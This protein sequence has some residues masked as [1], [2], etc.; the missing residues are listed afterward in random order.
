MSESSTGGENVNP[1]EVEDPS[2]GMSSIKY[3]DDLRNGLLNY[4][5][6][7]DNY[8]KTQDPLNTLAHLTLPEP[9]EIKCV[10]DMNDKLISS[11]VCWRY[12]KRRALTLLK[13]LPLPFVGVKSKPDA[14]VTAAN[15]TVTQAKQTT[16][17]CYL[18][19]LNEC[20]KRF[21]ILREFNIEEGV[22]T[23]VI[24]P[25]SS[26]PAARLV[27]SRVW[28][29]R[30]SREAKQYIYASS[31]VAST[32]VDSVEPSQS[33]SLRKPGSCYVHCELA[34]SS[35]ELKINTVAMRQYQLVTS[36]LLMIT[37]D[38]Y[39]LK[40]LLNRTGLSVHSYG[41][42]NVDYCEYR[43]LTVRSLLD[44][45]Q[46][47]FLIDTSFN[48]NATN[49]LN[50]QLETDALNLQMSQSTL[51]CLK[52]LESEWSSVLGG[53]IRPRV[54]DSCDESIHFYLIYN[55]TAMNMNI[56]QVETEETCAL[57]RGAYLPYTWRTHKKPQLVQIYLPK[58]KLTS[59][60]FQINRNGVEEL[61]FVFPNTNDS[62]FI[63][64]VVSVET[65]YRPG[66]S[67]C[68]RKEFNCSFKKYIFIQGK[69]L[70]C[71][72]AGL[73]VDSFYLNYSAVAAVD[74]SPTYELTI[75]EPVQ[76]YSRST[77][78]YELIETGA[79]LLNVNSL[80]LNESTVTKS[81]N[82]INKLINGICVVDRRANYKYWINLYE[83]RFD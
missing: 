66:Q 33:S 82:F 21:V 2:T 80:R 72:Y 14:A 9:N 69:F 5:I 1:A 4:L 30:L 12:G 52:K 39:A 83:N 15:L 74:S 28:R 37:L 49:T 31:L 44:A 45:L 78:T 3:E 19:Y 79:G 73:R 29:I 65:K 46:F 75:G 56:K 64:C 36:D 53:D 10:D 38:Q 55:D 71:N 57:Q 47:K 50:V 7:D 22:Q 59:R 51:V 18:E 23:N 67:S 70:L 32:R 27:Y 43:F 61:R 6:V 26:G 17:T 16:L 41:Q 63:S 76:A 11:Y 42:L 35:V 58:Y 62:C 77:F 54:M 13:I 40:L 8:V 24:E 25:S 81:E 34:L 60:P 68:R 20:T 48:N